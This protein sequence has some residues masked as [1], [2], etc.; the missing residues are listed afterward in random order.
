MMGRI[1]IGMM[2]RK[3]QRILPP[4]PLKLENIELVLLDVNNLAVIHKSD[5]WTSDH[6]VKSKSVALMLSFLWRRYSGVL[7]TFQPFTF[8]IPPSFYLI[9]STVI[10]VACPFD[11]K[12]KKFYH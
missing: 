8:H 4:K 7:C 6:I 9:R 5:G 2:E 3:G 12:V 10:H 1:R 11:T